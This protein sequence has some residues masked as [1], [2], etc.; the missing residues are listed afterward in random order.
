MRRRWHCARPSCA[1]EASSILIMATTKIPAV[2]ER[3]RLPD[4]GIEL[5]F[6]LN[7][8]GSEHLPI[9]EAA[10]VLGTVDYIEL[11]VRIEEAGVARLDV[12][13]VRQ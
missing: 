13:V 8:L 2:A 12:T 6:V 7:V 1:T 9:A 5:Q 10:D 11:A 3:H 4:L